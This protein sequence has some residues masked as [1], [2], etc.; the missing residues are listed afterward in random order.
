M[1]FIYFFG[2]SDFWHLAFFICFT[3]R[4]SLATDPMV[5]WCGCVGSRFKTVQYNLYWAVLD[6]LLLVYIM[7]DILVF[8]TVWETLR[9]GLKIKNITEV[10]T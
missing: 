10:Y 5:A 7:V 1:S 8:Q 2:F 6:G 4:R 9:G 3:A